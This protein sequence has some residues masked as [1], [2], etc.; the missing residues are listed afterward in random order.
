MNAGLKQA[1]GHY[2]HVLNSDDL[3]LDP[4]AYTELLKEG[5]RKNALVLIA[6]IGYFRR[7]NRHLKS[8]W[9]VDSIPVNHHEWR[10]Q[11]L[12]GL[13]YPHPGFVANSEIYKSESFDERYSLSA[14]Y[15]IMQSIL[16]GWANPESTLTCRQPLV[17]MAEGGASGHFLAILTGWRQLSAINQELGIQAPG[18]KRYWGKLRRRLRPLGQAV[19][20]SRLDSLDL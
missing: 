5:D 15:K 4:I 20:I 11:L 16:L 8:L 10:K 19:Y 3:L 17:A 18:L 14:D 7:P 1:R 12:L 9:S 13:H 6:S 2:T